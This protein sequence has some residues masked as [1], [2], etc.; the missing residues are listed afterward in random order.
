MTMATI[1]KEKKRYSL[2]V[3][4][5]IDPG[6]RHKIE[7]ALKALG[8]KITAGGTTVDMSECDISFSK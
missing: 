8:Y 1:K 3:T 2:I 5:A 7:D 6:E 4:P